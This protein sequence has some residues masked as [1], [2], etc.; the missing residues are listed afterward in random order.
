MIS[1]SYVV[2]C[3]ILA[4][5]GV[6]DG[7]LHMS[8]VD[9]RNW[10]GVVLI[11]GVALAVMFWRLIEA[12]LRAIAAPNL[13]LV[14]GNPV[15]QRISSMGALTAATIIVTV[16]V[17]PVCYLPAASSGAASVPALVVHVIS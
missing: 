17:Q 9:S 16:S 10:D 3:S 6:V 2:R 7:I 8:S 1:A 4:V 15:P 14:Y 5:A 12:H 11:S 13:Y